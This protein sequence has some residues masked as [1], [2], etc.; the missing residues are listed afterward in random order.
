MSVFK[1]VK[2]YLKVKTVE[3][4]KSVV[5][6]IQEV[7]TS[8]VEMISKNYWFGNQQDQQVEDIKDPW[9]PQ[10]VC[11]AVIYCYCCS[12]ILLYKLLIFHFPQAFFI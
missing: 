5:G 10:L 12:M 3:S 11:I 8:N 1:S 9:L 2:G 7:S 6:E 4:D